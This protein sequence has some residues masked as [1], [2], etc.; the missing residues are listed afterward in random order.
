MGTNLRAGVGQASGEE[1]A[2]LA[3]VVIEG[4]D[5]GDSTC[6][7]GVPAPMVGAWQR[8]RLG[9]L[10]I[11]ARW[12][13]MHRGF[14]GL[15]WRFDARAAQRGPASGSSSGAGERM[16]QRTVVMFMVMAPAAVRVWP[17]R[18]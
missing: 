3:A 18:G 15:L 8:S 9:T 7:G 5:Y 14:A 13:G 17:G 11:A 4:A 6:C 16:A 1:T 12:T 2:G 10:T